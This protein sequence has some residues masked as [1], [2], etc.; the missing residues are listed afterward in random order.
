MFF[1]VNHGMLL[2]VSNCLLILLYKFNVNK[3]SVQGFISIFFCQHYLCWFLQIFLFT[4]TMCLPMANFSTPET[5][6][7]WMDKRS[8]DVDH[9]NQSIDMTFFFITLN[10][11]NISLIFVVLCFKFTILSHSL[12]TACNINFES[13]SSFDNIWDC[14]SESLSAVNP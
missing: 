4:F 14:I 8:W 11:K 6:C 7:F 3:F 1:F 5:L 2:P 13:A 12:A 9:H 10:L